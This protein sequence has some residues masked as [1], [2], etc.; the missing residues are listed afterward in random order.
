MS[1]RLAFLTLALTLGA[2][3]S[4]EPR[5][6][7]APLL[8]FRVRTVVTAGGVRETASDATVTGPPGTDLT[9][10][11][12]AKGFTMTA[13]LKTDLVASGRVRVKAD[14]TARHAAGVSERG[15]GL[16]EEDEQTVIAEVA[17]DGSE[18]LAV[19]PFG[20]NPGGDE[21][22]IDVQPSLLDG[23]SSSNGVRRDSPEIR[24][25]DPGIGG[26]IRIDA[27]TAPHFFA[28]EA[29]LLRDGQPIATGGARCSLDEKQAFVLRRDGNGADS[30]ADIGV[31]VEDASCPDRI[32]FTFDISSASGAGPSFP[33]ALE[34]AGVVQAGGSVDYPLGDATVLRIRISPEG[35]RP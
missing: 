9:I 17:L 22:A 21:I 11:T 13:R 19:M 4:T 33:D 20:P 28:V 23:P 25:A 31:R 8:E 34:W 26:W 18:S 24:I 2:P 32:A 12:R 14:V 3:V 30:A 27:S 6:D 5:V 7:V 10:R 29:V 35:F 16:F 1:A 15:V